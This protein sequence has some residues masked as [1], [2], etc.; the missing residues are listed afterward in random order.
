M[1]E[2]SAKVAET[3]VLNTSSEDANR[4]NSTWTCR[5]GLLDYR[6][7]VIFIGFRDVNGNH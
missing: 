1:R 3:A 2:K 6:L 4:V 7:N 5:G